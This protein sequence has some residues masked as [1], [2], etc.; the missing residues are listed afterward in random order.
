MFQ[1]NVDTKFRESLRFKS[2]PFDKAYTKANFGL[3]F[4]SIDCA[5]GDKISVN[6]IPP[7]ENSQNPTIISE[8]QVIFQYGTDILNFLPLFLG[9]IVY[10]SKY[11]QGRA[12]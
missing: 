6:S 11:F 12:K 8:F 5:S 4:V 2:T 10:T 9:D 3:L 1:I 7:V